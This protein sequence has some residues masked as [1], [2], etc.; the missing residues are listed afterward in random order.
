M[1]P[2]LPPLLLRPTNPPLLP[3][4]A[5]TNLGKTPSFFKSMKKLLWWR[6]GRCLSLSVV[7]G[8]RPGPRARCTHLLCCDWPSGEVEK[9]CVPT[10]VPAFSTKPR[11]T[12]ICRARTHVR[13]LGAYL[14]LRDGR[15][16]RGVHQLREQSRAT[17]KPCLR[18]QHSGGWQA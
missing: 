7:C 10:V 17:L 12:A 2:S 8:N 3:P 16:R 6:G 5:Q 18:Q 13:G 4:P 9:T 1:D 14:Q 11:S 15:N